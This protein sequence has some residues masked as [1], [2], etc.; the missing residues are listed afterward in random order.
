M[1]GFI[2]LFLLT[3]WGR[4]RSLCLTLLGLPLYLVLGA[5]LMLPLEA[6]FTEASTMLWGACLALAYWSPIATH[7]EA[8]AT[9]P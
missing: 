1:A 9:G 2:G 8:G 3:R 7:I 4:M 6:M 5:I